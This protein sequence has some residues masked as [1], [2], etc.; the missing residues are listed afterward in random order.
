M[1]LQ[2]SISIPPFCFI[3]PFQKRLSII[4]SFFISK[5]ANKGQ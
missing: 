3:I 5:G 2:T 4:R 1:C